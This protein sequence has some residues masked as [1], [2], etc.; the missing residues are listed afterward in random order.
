MRKYWAISLIVI[1]MMWMAPVAL[2]DSLWSD[3]S[4]PLYTNER[5]FKVGDLLTILIAEQSSA[6]NQVATNGNEKNTFL[7]GPGAGKLKK[8]IPLLGAD[9]E[10]GYS[11]TGK[12]SRAGN[13]T[14]RLTVTVIS[15]DPNG[16]LNVEGS[17][18]IK[19]NKD[20]QNIHVK[21]RIR[22]QDVS[23]DNSV[24]SSYIAD[25]DIEYK[26]TG[27]GESG[28]PGIISRILSWLF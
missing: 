23:A 6:S 1:V 11:G 20:E 27:S 12:T 13:L 5:V 28:Q 21:G 10:N 18:M 8:L 16:I 3:N 7:M 26:G 25:A 19:V 14:A 17:Q 22:P 4:R 9:S 15:I 24:L 2:G